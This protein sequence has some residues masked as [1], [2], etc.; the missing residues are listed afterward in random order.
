MKVSIG[1]S[2]GK[3]TIIDEN[4][5]IWKIR[6]DY[7]MKIVEKLGYIDLRTGAGWYKF[8]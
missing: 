5:K 7:I 8:E 2:K 1:I 4:K 6:I 3:L